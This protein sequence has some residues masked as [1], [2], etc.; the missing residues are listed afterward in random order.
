MPNNNINK[1]VENTVE[2][3]QPNRTEASKIQ[4]TK[5][6]KTAE[7]IFTSYIKENKSNFQY[8]SYDNFRTN[9]FKK[10]APFDGLLFYKDINESTLKNIIDKINQEITKSEFGKV[11]DELKSECIKNKIYIV[12]V[13][14]TRISSRHKINGKISLE[15][16]LNDDFLEYPKFLRTDK[17]GKINN[18]DDYIDFAKKYRKF[19]CKDHID[20]IQKIKELEKSNMRHLYFRIY[21]DLDTKTAYIIGYIYFVDFIKYCTLKKMRKRN[22]SEFALYLAAPLKNGEKID[23][24]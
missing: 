8:L 20:C 21:I 17:Y 11:S 19:L 14:S 10:H 9:N 16:I 7:N 13:K 22:K 15:K 3:W 6:G 4:D 5:I 24:L 23:N 12:E 18:F 2:T 1:I